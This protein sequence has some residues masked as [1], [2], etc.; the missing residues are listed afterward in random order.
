[1]RLELFP[2]TGADVEADLWFS[3]VGEPRTSAGI[4]LRQPAAQWLRQRLSEKPS[5]LEAAWRV[6]EQ[7]HRNISP[8]IFAEEKLAV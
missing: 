5:V 1:M 8:A 4:V 3:P 2:T 6:T 7:V